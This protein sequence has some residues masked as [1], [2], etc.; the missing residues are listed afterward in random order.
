MSD[1]R[2]SDEELFEKYKD[3]VIPPLIASPDSR[4]GLVNGKLLEIYQR[5]FSLVHSV[6]LG[7]LLPN[8]TFQPGKPERWNEGNYRP[9]ESTIPDWTSLCSLIRKFETPSG[10]RPGDK[11]CERCDKRK[12]L[13]A[14]G[15]GK[16]IAYLCPHGLIDMAVPVRLD[17][18]TIAVLFSGQRRP[19]RAAKWPKDLLDIDDV[20][21]P[22]NE[23]SPD[24]LIESRKR[25]Q[26]LTKLGICVSE[27]ETAMK[28]DDER[29]PGVEVGPNEIEGVL[30]RMDT[31]AL[32]L[33]TLASNTYEFEKARLVSVIRY[34]LAQALTI[35]KEGPSNWEDAL[36]AMKPQLLRF[37]MLYGLDYAALCRIVN[38]EEIEIVCQ[39]GLDQ[40][41]SGSN[42]ISFNVKGTPERGR[43]QR[44][45]GLWEI[46]LNFYSE[47]SVVAR[48]LAQAKER[49]QVFPKMLCAIREDEF[50]FVLAMG[51]FRPGKPSL[52]SS[53]AKSVVEIA[54]VAGLIAET[55][56][57]LK[58]LHQAEADMGH[59]L[60][61][62][63]HDL[64]GPIQT[65]V[66]KAAR[67]KIAGLSPDEYRDQARKLA[68]ACMRINLLAHRVWTAQRLWRG[69]LVYKDS[70]VSV[71]ETVKKVV[72]TF[73]DV[74]E[75]EGVDVV[76]DWD[77]LE[78]IRSVHV[79]SDMLFECVLN[80]L[81]NAIKYSTPSS[82]G[83]RSQV[84]IRGRVEGGR[85]TISIGNRG[86][87]LKKADMP[88]IFERYY[89]TEEAIRYKPEGTGIGLSI[90][91]DFVTH[92]KGEANVTC[93]PIPGTR[94]YKTIFEVNI[95][96][97]TRR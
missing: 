4:F 88:H 56:Y 36:R 96:T 86:I 40:I 82:A 59:L 67:F 73:A 48:I 94:E 78:Q 12:A 17:S 23:T 35:P 61:D 58:N 66:N 93:D 90:V 9:N 55:L 51:A 42:R 60:E 37:A 14:E 52:S 72:D 13:T 79:D 1:Q 63:A 46:D 54:A 31:A 30:T 62:V 44:F 83:R 22:E 92:Y 91:K 97:E 49:A 6:P 68:A 75:R 15:K 65:I 7:V 10:E 32:H 34:G 45:P 41:L 70:T 69:K 87:V 38:D 19:K 50:G 80:I 74:G 29:Q 11:E 24:L 28:C 27:I 21:T 43:V 2:L 47:L 71:K 3:G 95:P 77:E 84:M 89:R 16:A 20:Q 53:D 64:R 26:G 18:Q 33:S 85:W 5:G 8:L 81:H 76:V 39:I 57:L 25:I